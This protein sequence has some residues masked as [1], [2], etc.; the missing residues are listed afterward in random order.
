MGKKRKRHDRHYEERE[1][2]FY[3]QLGAAIGGVVMVTAV[4]YAIRDW[5]GLPWPATILLVVGVLIGLGYAAWW[6]KSRVQRAWAKKPAE[7]APNTLAQE[8]PP[9]GEDGAQVAVVPHPELTRALVRTGAID[10]D[11]VIPLHDV[12]TTAL[13]VGTQYTFLLPFGGTYEDVAKRLGPIASMLNVTRL[14]L[15]LEMSRENE[16]QITLLVLKE[17]PFSRLFDP[18]NREQIRAFDGIPLGHDVTGSLFGVETFD[19]ASMLIAG[20]S[21]MGK[22]TLLNG[23]IT[24]LFLAYGDDFDL[25]LLD[26]K[27]VG[28]ARFKEVAL[29]YESS[30]DPAVLENILDELIP[31]VDKRYAETEKAIQERRPGPKFRRLFFIVDEAADFYV[32]NGTKESRE[33]VARVE[34]KSRYLVAKALESGV[35]V[36][37]LTQRPDKDAIPVNVRAQFQYRACLYVDSEGAA[38]VAL[39]DSYFTTMAPINPVRFNPKHK[40]QAVLF[41][42]GKS[43]HIRGF[44][45]PDEFIWEVIDE[46]R[47]RHQKIL[48]AAPDTPLKQ[49]IDLLRDKGVE[50]M[51]TADLAPALGIME[52]RAGERGRQ[53]SKLLNVSPGKDEAGVVRGYWLTD[54]TAA[55][56]A[57]S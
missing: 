16:R 47:E 21:Q 24:C 46:T 3:G 42:H 22:T 8:S 11:D 48:S 14:H 2:D 25:V 27:F 7:K 18:P 56:R 6:V 28:L 9:T 10:K 5:L 33:Q 52:S 26:G 53:L 12:D 54:L 40:G 39:G 20:M 41:V 49:A 19:R 17:P 13:D 34:E 50:F 1:E 38:K 37:F 57:G 45:F 35:S 31:L 51:A 30:T 29:R 4:L 32:S 43:T 36:I 44:N 15:K 55:F 23:L